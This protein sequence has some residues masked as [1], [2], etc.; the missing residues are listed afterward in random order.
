MG[1]I[2]LAALMPPSCAV[3]DNG[4]YGYPYYYDF[5]RGYPY[6]GHSQEFDEHHEFEEHHEGG[7]HHH[8]RD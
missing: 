6:Y 2:P 7:E 5:D 3:Y 4:Y 8:N 1:M